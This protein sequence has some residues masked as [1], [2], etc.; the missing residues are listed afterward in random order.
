MKREKEGGRGGGEEG[1]WI[2]RGSVGERLRERQIESK[3]ERDR[4]T[5]RVRGI[6]RE[7]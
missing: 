3:K 5:R 6:G 2:Q 1:E 7:R 4:E